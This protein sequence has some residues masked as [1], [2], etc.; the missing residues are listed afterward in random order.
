MTILEKIQQA[1]SK[2]D[3]DKLTMQVILSPDHKVN[4]EA[5]RVRVEELEGKNG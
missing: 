5:F 3:L 2:Q 4:C 1:Q